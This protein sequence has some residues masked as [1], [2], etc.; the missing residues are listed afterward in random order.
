MVKITDEAA[1]V[2]KSAREQNG[3]GDEAALRLQTVSG[4]DGSSAI[5]VT[6]TE[7]PETD[8]VVGKSAGVTVYVEPTLAEELGDVVLDVK[9][10]AEGPEL[11][12]RA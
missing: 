5:G 12:L 11:V 9:E 1:D 8:D 10:T 3:F 6:F 2:I 7:E 4:Q